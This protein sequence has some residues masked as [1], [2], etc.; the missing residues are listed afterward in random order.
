MLLGSAAAFAKDLP[1]GIA[2]HYDDARPLPPGLGKKI[3]VVPAV[4][5]PGAAIL[6]AGGL[7]VAATRLRRRTD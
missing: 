1:P 6:F 7:A 2:N 4:P 3:D 5:E